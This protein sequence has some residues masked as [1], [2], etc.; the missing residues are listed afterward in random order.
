M[1]LKG[2]FLTAL[3]LLGQ[4]NM[5]ADNPHATSA[6]PTADTATQ[7]HVSFRFGPTPAV[8][9]SNPTVYQGTTLCPASALFT[10]PAGNRFVI[11]NVSGSV[12]YNTNGGSDVLEQLA[13]LGLNVGGNIAF[14][15]I[16]FD[17]SQQVGTTTYFSFNQNV[18]MFADPGTGF[19]V[20]ELTN[21]SNGFPFFPT[22]VG[23]VSLVFQGYL[24]PLS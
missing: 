18:H 19:P 3:A 15:A 12:T 5:W 6:D 10:V 4:G 9:C 24:V 21:L 20:V 14:S 13:A 17:H 8:T 2:I 22:G 7:I 11:T 1:K 16:P 23:G